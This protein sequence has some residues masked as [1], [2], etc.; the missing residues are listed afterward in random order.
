MNGPVHRVLDH[1]TAQRVGHFGDDLEALR[2]ARMSTDTETGVDV[3]KDDRLRSRLMYK[4]HTSPFEGSFLKY[5]LQLPLFC[6]RQIDRHRTLDEVGMSM[7]SSDEIPRQFLSRN[8]FSGRYSTMPDLFYVPLPELVRRQSKTNKQSSEFVDVYNE[9]F[10]ADTHWSAE[11]SS[12]QYQEHIA[13]GVSR[14]QARMNLPLNQYTRVRLSGTC[15]SWLKFLKLRL[16]PDVQWE[17]RQFAKAIGRDIRDLWPKT[18]ATFED[19]WLY[20]ITLRRKDFRHI[21]ILEGRVEFSG[22]D[23]D[24]AHAYWALQADLLAKE[25]NESWE[26]T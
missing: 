18:W 10:V 15:L 5:E 19:E 24:V 22:V 11:A 6:L 23:L 20:T 8:E 21:Q 17:T 7:E 13:E 2:D 12:A 9:H 1:G 25:P 14:E 26:P 3:R 4:F 16:Q